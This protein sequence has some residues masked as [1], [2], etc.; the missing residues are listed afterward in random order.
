MTLL[1]RLRRTVALFVCPEMGVEA[2]LKA[3]RT[4]GD[5]V[6]SGF[7]D[8]A[9]RAAARGRLDER[10][11]AIRNT[12][13][14]SREEHAELS[15]ARRD[16]RI[17]R[18]KEILQIVQEVQLHGLPSADDPAFDAQAERLAVLLFGNQ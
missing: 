6:V 7:L 2:R 4:N 8:K 13:F 3:M 18:A 10:G 15:A 17:E 14:F 1:Y 5:Y 9:A 16:R 12:M 11:E